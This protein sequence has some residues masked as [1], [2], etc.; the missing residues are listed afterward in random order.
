MRKE[1]SDGELEATWG[2]FLFEDTITNDRHCALDKERLLAMDKNLVFEKL[3]RLPDE[4]KRAVSLFLHQHTQTPPLSYKSVANHFDVDIAAVNG[5]LSYGR[6]LFFN[7][8]EEA[9]RDDK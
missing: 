6:Y 7:I 3:K 4:K 8:L 5:I 2:S 1:P 9:L